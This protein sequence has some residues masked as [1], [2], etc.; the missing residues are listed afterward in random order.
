M[1]PSL[2]TTAPPTLMS[3]TAEIAAGWFPDPTARHERRYWNGAAWT[4]HVFTAG[5]QSTDPMPTATDV[6]TAEEAT[7]ADAPTSRRSARESAA[8]QNTVSTSP[9]QQVSADVDA[10]SRKVFVLRCEEPG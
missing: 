5:S 7:V 8:A 9:A 4:E 6:E 2:E 3:N 10:K 1:Q